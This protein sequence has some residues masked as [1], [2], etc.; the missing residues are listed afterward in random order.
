MRYLI[1]LLFLTG[2]NK[3]SVEPLTTTKTHNNTLIGK[4]VS[5][6][7]QLSG[8]EMI[9]KNTDTIVFDETTMYCYYKKSIIGNLN[10]SE[11]WYSVGDSLHTYSVIYLNDDSINTDDN[12]ADYYYK[13]NGNSLYL[14]NTLTNIKDSYIKGYY[15]K[16]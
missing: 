2:C 14:Y 9:I 1:I 5:D 11:L 16:I 8:S 7:V 15:H 3:E 6:S 4:W 10:S 13:V 12:I